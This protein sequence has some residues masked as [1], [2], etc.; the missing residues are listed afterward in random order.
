M[1]EEKVREE[2]RKRAIEVMDASRAKTSGV[3][4]DST[5]VV[6]RLRDEQ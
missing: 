5:E 6:R 1:V 3:K 4:F 2:R